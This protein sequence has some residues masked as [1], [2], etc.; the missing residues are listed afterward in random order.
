MN[1]KVKS[2]LNSIAGPFRF[3]GGGLWRLLKKI[4]APSKKGQL[5]WR[6]IFIVIITLAAALYDYPKPYNDAAQAINSLASKNGYSKWIK[7]PAAPQISWKLGLDLLGGTHLVYE[8]DMSAIPSGD[9][10][11]A[12]AGVRDVIERRVNAF[13]VAEPLVQT[14]RDGSHYRLIVEL[15]GIKDV[16]QAIKMIGE[17][18]TLDFRTQAVASAPAATPAPALTPAMIAYNA[19]AKKKADMIDKLALAPGADF[20]ALAKQYS[21]DPGSKEK[22]GDLGFFAKGAMVKP[23][24]DAVFALK[25]GEITKT[26]VLS[27]FGYHIIKKTGDKIVN[28]QEEVSASHI[29]IT[30]ESPAAPAATTDQN[31]GWAMT[32]LSGKDLSRATVVFDPQS[33]EPT[34]QLT[35]NAEGQKLFGDITGA[36]IGKPLGIFLDGQLISAPTVQ[37]KITGGTAVISGN[38]TLD[39]TKTLSQRLNAGALPVP[40]N[41]ITQQTVDATLGSASLARSLFAGIIGFLAVVLFMLLIYRL[42]GLMAALALSVYTALTLGVF[43]LLGVTMT[44]AGIAGFI[45]SIGMAV[46]ANVLIF[47]R[48]KEELRNNRTMGEALSEGFKRA[49]NSIRDSNISSLITC[50]ILI[51]FGTSTVRGFAITLAIGILLSM[52]TAIIVTRNFIRSAIGE[53]I[54]RHL[55]L[56]GSHLKRKTEENK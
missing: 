46:D 19:A 30:T 37:S 20:A 53:R 23:F 15:A 45:L 3:F 4:F 31:S 13:G 47:E 24:E 33:G 29:L 36:N 41:L 42:P 21:E 40:I 39:E 48:V 28:G 17:T 52:F 18:P 2:A 8:A 11:S 51:W 49:W 22:G 55:W 43:K 6:I 5:R 32:Q 16:N 1:E 9:R 38:F 27:Q 10:D 14:E 35:W 54:S 12:L 34:V 56:I 7:L 26:P 50:A 44:L 25:V